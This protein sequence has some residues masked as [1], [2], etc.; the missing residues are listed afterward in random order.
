[1]I[2]HRSG[3]KD[4]TAPTDKILKEQ[5]SPADLYSEL[6]LIPSI[7]FLRKVLSEIRK[8]LASGLVVLCEAGPAAGIL[9]FAAAC[10]KIC[11]LANNT[12][13]TSNRVKRNF[14]LIL[15]SM[16][17]LRFSILFLG[18]YRTGLLGRPEVVQ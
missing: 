11:T 7:L 4:V 8:A 14:P 3:K 6:W 12:T 1:M 17:S 5:P 16:V 15:I 13:G 2:G 9:S 10:A 18:F